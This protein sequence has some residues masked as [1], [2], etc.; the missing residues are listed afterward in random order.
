MFVDAQVTTPQ[1][2]SVEPNAVDVAGD[3]AFDLGERRSRSASA[4]R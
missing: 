4:A 2:P 3:D 1:P